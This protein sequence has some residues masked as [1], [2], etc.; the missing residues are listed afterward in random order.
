VV[1]TAPAPRTASATEHGVARDVNTDP[2][3]VDVRSDRRHPP[4]PLVPE[5]HRVVRMTLL[6]VR[7]LTSEELDVRAAHPDPF[8]VDDHLTTI[9]ARRFDVVD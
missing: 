9:R 5:A 3:G 6:Q 1:T 7:H 4:A 8:D 2:F